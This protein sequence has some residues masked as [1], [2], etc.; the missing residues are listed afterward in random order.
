LNGA[1]ENNL[2]SAVTSVIFSVDGADNISVEEEPYTVQ[3]NTVDLE[4]GEY[5]V[6][7][8]VTNEDGDVAEDQLTIFITTDVNV[9]PTVSISGV[10]NNEVITR[11]TIRVINSNITDDNGSDD[12]DRVK[13][14]IA[15]VLVA[16]VSEAPF[17]YEW[18]SFDNQ[19]GTFVISVTGFDNSG[20][21]RS[22]FVNVE[23]VDPPNYFPRVS[24]TSPNNGSLFTAG[25]TITLRATAS[26]IEFDDI[27]AV[28]FYLNGFTTFLNQ[29]SEAPYEFDWDTNGFAAGEYTIEAVAFDQNC[30]YNGPAS[31]SVIT[32]TITE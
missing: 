11:Q 6:S 31:L 4:P 1:V 32:I 27:C 29:D 10:N 20:A 30:A 5:T 15:G 25:S 9:A 16:T 2:R 13:F 7:V 18:D 28:G 3:F 12:I 21:Q 23:L 8:T 14:R 19:V 22:D 26:D 17:T 24:I